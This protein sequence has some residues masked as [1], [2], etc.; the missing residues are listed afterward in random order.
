MNLVK[1][2]ASI[3]IEQ[4]IPTLFLDIY[5]VLAALNSFSILQLILERT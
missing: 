3:L 5:L 1:I 2:V 4:I